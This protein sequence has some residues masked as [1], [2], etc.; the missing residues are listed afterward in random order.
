MNGN[1]GEYTLQWSMDG[2]SF[3]PPYPDADDVDD[4]D[5]SNFPD[6]SQDH[7]VYFATPVS[8]RYLRINVYSE[9]GNRGS[10]A[11]AAEINI[12]ESGVPITAPRESPQL[13]N[14]GGGPE[15]G[16]SHIGEV[17]GGLLG[18]IAA[19]LTLLLSVYFKCFRGRRRREA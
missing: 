6:D 1:I 14:Q 9:A 2:K 7:D 10:W 12:F 11:S 13:S 17:V 8:A 16:D 19:V 3:Y 5:V 15:R 4:R 18:G